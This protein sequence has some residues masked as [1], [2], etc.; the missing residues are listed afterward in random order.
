[1]LRDYFGN[2]DMPYL[3][4]LAKTTSVMLVNTHYSLNGVRPNT[5]A[6][7]EVGGLH[8]K[9]ATKKLDPVTIIG[10]LMCL[11]VFFLFF[12]QINFAMR[13]ITFLLLGIGR[14]H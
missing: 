5:P 2:D 6:V 4:E 1:M 14:V 7:I 9:N 12:I 8:I 3:G 11:V 10:F 13:R